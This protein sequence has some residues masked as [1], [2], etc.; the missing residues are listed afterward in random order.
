[1]I[2]TGFIAWMGV[3]WSAAMTAIAAIALFFS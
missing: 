1:M 3:T 2:I